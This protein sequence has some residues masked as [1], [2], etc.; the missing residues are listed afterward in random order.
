MDGDSKRAGDDGAAGGD[1]AGGASCCGVRP[2]TD[3]DARADDRF[4]DGEGH[5]PDLRRGVGRRRRGVD[6]RDVAGEQ[7]ESRVGLTGRFVEQSPAS[8]RAIQAAGHTI[9]NHSYSHPDFTTLTQAQRFAELDKAEAAFRAAGIRYAKWFRAPFKGGYNS[10]SLARDLALKGYYVN[11]DWTY[12]TT[13]YKGSSTSTILSRV[14]TL[15]KPGT[16]FLGHVGSASTDAEA[17]PSVLRV[18]RDEMGYRFTDASRT[19]TQGDIR[20]RYDT[21]RHLG[22]PRTLERAAGTTGRV[23]W[24]DKGRI[25][26]TSTTGARE[27]HGKILTKYLQH[28]DTASKPGFPTTSQRVTADGIGRYNRFQGGSIYWTSA[29]GAHEVHGKIHARWAGLGYERSWLGYPVTDQYRTSTGAR[30]DFQHG[31]ILWNST[32]GATSVIRR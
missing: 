28:G 14:R 25:Y 22:A 12:D 29:L 19:L 9:F 32:T 17:L 1:A 11:L 18:L 23:Q 3:G 24:F 2:S 4:R 7:R 27:V 10:D 21:E 30:S 20:A 26:W 13:G 31:S 8:S 16:I 5:H 6:P 15:T